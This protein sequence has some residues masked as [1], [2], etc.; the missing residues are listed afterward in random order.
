MCMTCGCGPDDTQIDGEHLRHHHE[1]DHGH[2]D[3]VHGPGCGHDHSHDHASGPK[4]DLTEADKLITGIYIRMATRPG[5]MVSAAMPQFA[6]ELRGQSGFTVAD[7]VGEMKKLFVIVSSIDVIFRAMAVIVLVSSGIAIMLALYNS[8]NERRR[9]I[10][11]LRVL[12]SSRGRIFGLVV[13]ESALLGVLGAVVGL[14]ISLGGGLAA[15]TVLQSR[16]GLVIRP[17]Y[18]LE[19]VLLVVVGAVALAALAGVIPAVMAYR[20]SV[21]KNLRPLG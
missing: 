2:G 6:S 21:A 9:Q 14:F 1:H 18:G 11:V 10:A 15:A 20:T 17:V 19:W 4:V 12:G 16:V 3:H 13:T 8:M 7:P 5:A